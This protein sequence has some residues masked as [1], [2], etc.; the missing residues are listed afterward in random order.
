MAVV[1]IRTLIS[2]FLLSYLCTCF[3]LCNSLGGDICG[4]SYEGEL[5]GGKVIKG[6]WTARELVS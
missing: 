3:G 6:C 5:W 2:S 4:D 1:A